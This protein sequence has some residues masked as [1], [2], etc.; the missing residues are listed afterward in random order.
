MLRALL[1]VGIAT[2][3][4]L[5]VPVVVATTSYEKTAVL[6]QASTAMQAKTKNF[7]KSFFL[8]QQLI[9]SADEPEP[10][11]KSTENLAPKRDISFCRL[12][13]HSNSELSC[14]NTVSLSIETWLKRASFT[15]RTRAD[16]TSHGKSDSCARPPASQQQQPKCVGNQGCFY[17][18][19]TARRPAQRKF[20]QNFQL[21][22]MR[23]SLSRRKG[24]ERVTFT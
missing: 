2:F 21:A 4:P 13:L 6:R 14:T 24:C 17:A 5:H 10:P 12:S 16:E 19:S 9:E 15:L 20:A 22:S 3:H 8:H 18:R 1:R 23:K 7:T 11:L